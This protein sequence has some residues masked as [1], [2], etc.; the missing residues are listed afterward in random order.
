MR[1]RENDILRSD[2]HIVLE[3]ED[4]M[5]VLDT[6][7]EQD[8]TEVVQA[9]PKKVVIIDDNPVIVRLYSRLFQRAGFHPLSADNG[10]GGL[11][12]ILAKKPEAAVI[13]CHMSGLSGFEICR[14]VRKNENYSHTLLVLF[15]GDDEPEQRKK[16]LDA[17]ADGVVLK[18]P[19][20]SVLVEAVIN[21]LNKE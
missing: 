17:G 11:K 13:D 14:A 16:A 12:L 2:P 18:S 3:Q 20:A 7:L 9:T 10:I 4:M 6:G 1:R 5:L 15:T 19:D 8:E 21:L